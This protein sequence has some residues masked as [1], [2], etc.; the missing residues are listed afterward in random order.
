MHLR[1]RLDENMQENRLFLEIS[2]QKI[3]QPQIVDSIVRRRMS[4]V[5]LQN[6]GD[7]NRKTCLRLISH[8]LS[9]RVVELTFRISCFFSPSLLLVHIYSSKTA[10][11]LYS[12]KIWK[13]F[14]L[15]DFD[16][17]I[18]LLEYQQLPF[19]SI[20]SSQTFV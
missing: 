19:L 10:F 4:G 12:V 18:K 3:V 14:Y 9:N 2:C 13:I 6:Q 15:S 5:Q 20:R 11:Q 8:H 16:V 1:I 17:G 7:E